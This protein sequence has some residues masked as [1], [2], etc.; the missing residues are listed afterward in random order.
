MTTEIVDWLRREHRGEATDAGSPPAV[1]LP[2]LCI[3]LVLLSTVVVWPGVR[4]SGAGAGV[5]GVKPR[6]LPCRRARPNR[7]PPVL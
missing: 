6:L 3:C 7:S 5:S 1:L 4:R 2:G